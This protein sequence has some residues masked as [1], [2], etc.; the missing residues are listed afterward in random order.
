MKKPGI[1]FLLLIVILCLAGCSSGDNTPA[2]A[3]QGKVQ[4]QALDDTDAGKGMTAKEFCE[5]YEGTWATNDG[6]F[7]YIGFQTETGE[8]I[9][10]W[11]INDSDAIYGPGAIS[12]IK[13]LD[14]NEY[15]LTVDYPERGGEVGFTYDAFVSNVHISYR[16]AEG[17]L[18]AMKFEDEPET[19][20]YFDDGYGGLRFETAEDFWD[21]LFN[22]GMGQQLI[23]P[24]TDN[25]VQFFDIGGSPRFLFGTLGFNEDSGIGEITDMSLDNHALVITVKFPEFMGSGGDM[26]PESIIS[27]TIRTIGEQGVAVYLLDGGHV[28]DY[29]F[30]VG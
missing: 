25:Y 3:D 7:V 11:G 22:T 28:G 14:E 27:Y 12:D 24:D 18:L 15:D 20:Y 6:Y 19:E 23:D 2:P 16:D 26:V 13:V 5:L 8:P 30:G 4:E 9:F 21:Y 1:V 29:Y 10:V 17:K